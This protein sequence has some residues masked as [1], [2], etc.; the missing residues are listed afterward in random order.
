MFIIKKNPRGKCMCLF[1]LGRT[2]SL[3]K[4]CCLWRRRSSCVKVSIVG[5]LFW[6][7]VV[8][9]CL[10]RQDDLH[11]WKAYSPIWCC[12]GVSLNPS[13][14]LVRLERG[15]AV[16]KATEP[17]CSHQPKLHHKSRDMGLVWQLSLGSYH[18]SSGLGMGPVANLLGAAFCLSFL[19]V[20][21]SL[22]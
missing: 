21:C 17:W 9:W 2:S 13:G 1:S 22:M 6:K 10:A 14:A 5:N 16:R 20:I 3:Q 11:V 15:W 18:S 8:L 7:G 4:A 19:N 12:P